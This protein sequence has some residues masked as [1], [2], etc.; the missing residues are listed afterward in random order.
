VG[1]LLISGNAMALLPDFTKEQ[2]ITA[3]EEIVLGTVEETYSAWADDHSQI[4]TYVT[5]Q[6]TEQIKGDALGNTVTVQI[7]GGKVGE[8]TQV[9]S[10]TPKNLTIGSEVLLHLFMQDTGY[11]WIY[12]WEKGALNVANRRI[13]AYNMTVD[14]FRSLVE[15]TK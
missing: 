8:I 3:S 4:F 14:Q 1:I 9:T 2:L 5:L 7:P 10:D 6:I 11:Y 13:P 15:A 12:G